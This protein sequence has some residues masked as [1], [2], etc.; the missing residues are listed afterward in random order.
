MGECS[1]D[2]TAIVENEGELKK[3]DWLVV[4]YRDN[5]EWIDTTKFP[6]WEIPDEAV[7]IPHFFVSIT[8]A[9]PYEN[10]TTFVEA[11]AISKHI[12]TPRADSI[13]GI[14]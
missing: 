4:T 1:F 9:D 5:A 7:P 14:R 12:S 2:V 13:I 10:Q 8:I 11:L 3:G 6:E